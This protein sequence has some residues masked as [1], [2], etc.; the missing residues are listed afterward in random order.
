MPIT[1][2]SDLV[3]SWGGFEQWV[4]DL[5][6]TGEVA[7]ER[8]VT[9]VGRSGTT[10]QID[11]LLRHRHSFYE[12]L[13]VVECKYLARKVSRAAVDQL[14]ATIRDVG[15]SR[16]VIFSTS[17]FQKGA[18]RQAK[19]EFIELFR[20]R[21]VDRV[22]WKADPRYI[23][24]IVQ[25]VTWA[26]IHPRIFELTDNTFVE[27]ELTILEV[28]WDGVT[29]GENEESIGNARPEMPRYGLQLALYEYITK[30]WN[31]LRLESAHA[32]E[33]VIKYIA[34]ARVDLARTIVISDP[35][36]TVRVDRVE[37]EIGIHIRQFC[38]LHDRMDSVVFALAV[39][40]CVRG[41]LSPVVRTTQ[42]AE[43]DQW[44]KSDAT[45]HDSIVDADDTECLTVVCSLLAGERDSEC[46]QGLVPGTVVFDR[47]EGD[48]ARPL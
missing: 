4:A 29:E 3:T 32:H 19:H 14:S 40:D 36:E 22:T 45:G 41:L 44:K 8:N 27:H 9:I 13:V 2:I 10:R 25:V 18:I 30:S 11:V 35:T 31:M 21:D 15:A 7:V 43:P 39:E 20:V 24:T 46:F 23:R 37:T 38:E 42:L 33:G 28:R 47:H 17:G 26:Y 16:G 12:H 5:H 34:T 48:D 1:K 6:A